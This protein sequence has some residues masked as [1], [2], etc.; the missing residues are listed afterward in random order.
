M[1]EDKLLLFDLD[2]T[3][4]NLRGVG[5]RSLKIITKEILNSDKDISSIDVYGKTDTQIFEDIV[6]FI[7]FDKKNF[8]QIYNKFVNRY[9][10]YLKKEVQKI[11]F[12]PVINNIREFLADVSKRK[13]IYIGLLT[14][15]IKKGAKI[16]LSR[17]GILKYFK[18]GAFGDDNINRN[19]LVPI[20][21]K[22]AEELFSKKFKKKNIYII[23]DTPKDIEAAKKNNV[24]SVAIASGNYNKE[25]L[26]KFSPD[27]LFE[28]ISEF[29]PF[30]DDV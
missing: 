17:W 22:R 28:N 15:N 24:I 23:G 16:K 8:K 14:G 9:L 7:N 13:N 30:L 27:F 20:A 12:D 1:Q 18:F 5:F 2:G 11:D 19:K 3:L 21:K 10:Y 4:V 26:A 6:N 25:Y 29:L